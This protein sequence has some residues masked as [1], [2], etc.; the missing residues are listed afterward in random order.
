MRSEGYERLNNEI[1]LLLNYNPSALLAHPDVP[2]QKL[3]APLSFYDRHLDERLTLK[4]VLAAPSLGKDLSEHISR[5][6]ESLKDQKIILPLIQ[7]DDIFPTLESCEHFLGTD[8]WGPCISK[9][10]W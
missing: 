1:N 9:R 3:V 7:S 5:A 6:L 2:R 4:R 10:G 8:R